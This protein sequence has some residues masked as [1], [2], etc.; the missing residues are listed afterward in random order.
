MS[1]CGKPLNPAR[2]GV[3]KGQSRDN[4]FSVSGIP[5]VAGHRRRAENKVEV[6]K[7]AW[8]SLGPKVGEGREREGA[9]GGSHV[10]ES[11]WFGPW[12]E[13]RKAFQWEDRRGSLGES[14]PHHS[15]MAGL[16]EQR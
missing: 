4:R 6:L 15:N 1:G 8:S 5:E 13:F 16:D 9:L 11:P 3:D 12:L 14:L 2:Q 10:G 7:V